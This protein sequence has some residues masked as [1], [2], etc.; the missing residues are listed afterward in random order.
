MLFRSIDWTSDQGATNLHVNN[1]TNTTYT[2]GDNGLTEKNFTATLKTN[3]DGIE[4]SATADQTAAEIKTAYEANADTNEFSDAEQ[5][6]L[7][8]IDTSADV[9][10]ATTV[11]AAGAVMEADTTTAAMSFV[12]DEDNLSSD[13]STK[14]PTQQSVKAYVDAHTHSGYATM[15]DVIAMA[16]AL[17]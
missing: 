6:K 12:V 13:S 17:G 10:D 2:V 11:A 5:T 16:I 8:G 4:T 9:T 1:Y 7:S 15:D 14:V 3:L